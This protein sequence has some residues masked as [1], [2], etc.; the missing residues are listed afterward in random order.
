MRTPG[1]L[2]RA[3]NEIL[4]LEKAGIRFFVLGASDYPPGLTH[5]H[6]PPLL[7][8]YRG[9][10]LS[11]LTQKVCVSIVGARK[12]DQFA[13]DIAR[14]FAEQVA[15]SGGCVV[16]GLAFGID[17]HAH[18]GALQSKQPQTTVAVLGNGLEF[19]IYPSVHKKLADD[20][21]NQ[22]GLLLSQFPSLMKPFPQNFLDRNR[23]IAALSKATLIIQ[24]AERSGALA[25]A[26][27][28]MEL[29]RDVLVAPGAIGD[30][31]YTGS[32]RLIK[33]GAYLV[34]EIEDLYAL[35]PEL[36]PHEKPALVEPSSELE[37]KIKIEL[38]RG[39][40]LHYDQLLREFGDIAAV[41]A[42]LDHMEE[43]KLLTRLPGNFIALRPR[44]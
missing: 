10:D 13:C 35:I 20:I 40:A 26:R 14:D 9:E 21:L 32:N 25:T 8:F 2:T 38:E 27:H 17:A 4:R 16:S 22:G 28:A 24:A 23:V 39:E 6:E 3:E 43:L 1:I 36:T 15:T 12:A 41:S 11:L 34:S 31:R 19:G 44:I 37:L 29:G 30:L 42:A 18:L 7:I 5:L 33:Q